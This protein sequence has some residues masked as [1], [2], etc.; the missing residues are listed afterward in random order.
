MTDK[1]LVAR[2]RAQA[3]QQNLIAKSVMLLAADRIEQLQ[4]KPE[5]THIE[6]ARNLAGVANA[7]SEEFD[8]EAVYTRRTAR[9]RTK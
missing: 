4:K 5:P 1:E 8:V 9:S 7:G 3:E 2:L 6:S